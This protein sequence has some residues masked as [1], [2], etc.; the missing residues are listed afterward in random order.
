VY[1]CG[2]HDGI[3][4]FT[5]KLVEGG[6]LAER[7]GQSAGRWREIATLL[8]QVSEAV[9]HAH[10]RGVLHRDLKPGNVLFDAAGQVYVSDFGIA[11]LADAQQQAGLTLTNSLI[12]TPHYL[13]PEIA[14]SG[15]K[16]ASVA[17]DGWGLG[18]MLYELLTGAK[19]YEGESMT[20]VVRALEMEEALAPRQLRPDVPRDL[21][22]IAL[23][24]LSRESARRYAST[25]AF[26]DDLRAWLDGRPI[27]ARAASAPERLR[28][29]VRRNP[30]LAAMTVLLVLA[31]FAA[32]LSLLWGFVRVKEENVRVI[33]SEA[34][35]RAQLRESLFH[36]AHAGRIAHEMGWR[37]AGLQALHEAYA[38]QPGID[39]RDE[40]VAHLAGFDLELGSRR[41]EFAVF[42][43]RSMELY[44]RVQSGSRLS[45]HRM[46]DDEE[47]FRI[48][49]LPSMRGPEVT[50][51]PR[52][53]WVA[54]SVAEEA[55]VYSLPR[56][57]R[58]G[59]LA[60]GGGF[61]RERGW[62]V[63]PGPGKTAVGLAPHQRLVR[64]G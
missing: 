47:V 12:G 50:F 31:L 17:S 24:A 63:P 49:A 16:A 51:D 26:A 52:G 30:G 25:H 62:P 13:A 39:V 60:G 22:V 27:R 14:A 61:P 2:E 37:S 1:E 11:K 18:V 9:G 54:V 21:E 55:R 33:A 6:T 45:V 28:L 19:P 8:A 40:A 36:Q 43:S 5:M 32:A 64:R 23:K 46:R 29:W 35:A 7:L 41:F 3:P 15:A 38:I 48:P 44:V 56:W 10:D 20:Q 42:P 58:A 34:Q 53:H 57:P 59:A 4:F